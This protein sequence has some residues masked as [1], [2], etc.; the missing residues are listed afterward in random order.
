MNSF[1]E[2]NSQ[3]MHRYNAPSYLTGMG[4]APMQ[5]VTQGYLTMLPDVYFHTGASHS[6]MLECVEAATRSGAG[7]RAGEIDEGSPP[8]S[9]DPVLEQRARLCPVTLKEVKP[10]R[11]ELH[12]TYGVRVL[13]RHAEPKSL[14][15]VRG[16]LSESPEL[17]EA[18]EQPES[19]VD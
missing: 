13:R 11:G 1:Y 17:R 15:L 5:A 7:D 8:E 9:R 18:L 3:N 16:G 14:G 12:H 19:I 6:D 4:S 10:T 2:K